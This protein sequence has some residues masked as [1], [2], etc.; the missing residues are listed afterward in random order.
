MHLLQVTAYVYMYIRVLP[1]CDT[2]SHVYVLYTRVAC[3]LKR[4]I[5]LV[6]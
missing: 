1:R 5:D 3:V 2:P 6:Q 4:V